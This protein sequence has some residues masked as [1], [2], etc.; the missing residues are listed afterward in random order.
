M[1]YRPNIVNYVTYLPCIGAMVH[2]VYTGSLFNASICR[3]G[4]IRTN[5]EI[6]MHF[7]YLLSSKP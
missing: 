1:S 4:Y 2:L 6:I 3:R 7:F 5:K